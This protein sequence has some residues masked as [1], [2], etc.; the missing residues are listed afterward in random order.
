MASTSEYVSSCVL[1]GVA[2]TIWA[3]LGLVRPLLRP[4][5]TPAPI[6]GRAR[7]KHPILIEAW[8]VKEGRIEAGALGRALDPAAWWRGMREWLEVG[9]RG[10]ASALGD[11][12]EVAITV[13]AR[14]AGD[15]AGGTYAYVAAMYTD[16][17][18]AVWGDRT[19]ECG[20]RK[21]L[22]RIV[23][24]STRELR[25]E[26]PQGAP[27]ITVELAPV[28]RGHDLGRAAGPLI[29]HRLALPYL[30]GLEGGRFATS[31]MDR[32]GGERSIDASPVTGR[33]ECS[34]GFVEN[35]PAMSARLSP[36]S[37][38]DPWGALEFAGIRARLQHPRHGSL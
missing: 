15:A 10:A 7:G 3:D 25:V 21:R 4:W 36:L 16:S 19:M 2:A 33:I 11:Y 38:R 9:W 23:R 5:A 34:D 17:P 27:I 32:S 30:G 22:A 13:P 24:R 35:L 31:V 28:A 8:S 12:N 6:P 1:D 26:S 29:D 14:L 37:P 20:Y 18:V